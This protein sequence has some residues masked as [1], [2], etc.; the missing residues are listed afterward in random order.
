MTAEAASKPERTLICGDAVERDAEGRAVLVGGRC[1]D[2][3][4]RTFPRAPVCANCMSENI[5][6]ERLPR[7]GTLYAFSAV[8]IAP[9]KWK[10]PMTIGYVDL[11]DNVRVFTH[12]AGTEFAVGDTVEADI[13]TVGQ[14]EN[15]PIDCFVFK[16]VT[17]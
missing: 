4:T 3:G 10:M 5:A 2:C 8:H 16:R 1:T 14:D 6:P 17:A 11:P 7:Q 15:S 12:L 9:K 13:A